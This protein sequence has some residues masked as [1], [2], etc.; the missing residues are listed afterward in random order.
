MNCGRFRRPVSGH[1][2]QDSIGGFSAGGG[3]NSLSHFNDNTL[4][5]DDDVT[6]LHGKHQLVFGGEFV[7]NQLNVSNAYD[8][9]WPLGLR[10]Q[11]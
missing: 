11:L 1:R 8:Q 6:W 9:Q 3:T 4:A 7:R 5:I 10:E 2:R